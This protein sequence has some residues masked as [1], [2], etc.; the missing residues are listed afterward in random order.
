VVSR[1][2]ASARTRAASPAGS[3]TVNTTLA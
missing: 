2:R 3:L 1:S